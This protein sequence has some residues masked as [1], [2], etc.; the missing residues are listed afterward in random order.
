LDLL[1]SLRLPSASPRRDEWIQVPLTALI[2]DITASATALTLVLDD[3]HLISSPVVHQM[4]QFLLEHLPP[5]MHV[6]VGTREDPPL[7]LPLWRAR[8][9]VT[10]IR[11]RDLRFNAAETAAFLRQTMSL[12][13][14][15]EAVQALEARTEG[16]ITGLQLAALALQ[17]GQDEAQAFIAAVAGDNRYIIDYLIA[18]VLQRQPPA[19]RDFL[20]QT[21]IL[22]R[23]TA[24]LC[25]ALT[26]ETNSQATLDQLEEAN[27]FLVPLDHRR[28]WYRYHRLFAEFLRTRLTPEEQSALHQRAM[29]WHEE[30]GLLEQAIQHALALAELTGELQQAERLIR[31]AAED[32]IHSGG[33]L[34]LRGWLEALPDERVRASVEL[35]IYKG[36]VLALTGDMTLAQDYV[37]A[38]EA[39][40][41]QLDAPPAAWGKLVLLR[42]WI[43]LLGQRDHAAAAELA[44]EALEMLAEDQPHWRVIAL[45]MMAEALERT[46]NIA[47]AIML[48]RQAGQIGRAL[49]NQVFAAVVDMTLA[50]ALNNHGQRQQAVTVCQEAIERHSDATG[51][52]SP[53]AGLIFSRLGTLYYEANQLDLAC[54]CHER[55]LALSEKLAL[56]D[57][58]MFSHSF[59]VPTLYAQGRVTEALEA[60][61]KSQQLTT[62]TGFSDVDWYL[63]LQAN[64]YLKQGDLTFALHWAETAGLSPQDEPDYMRIEQQIIYA[65]VLLAQGRLAEAQSWLARLGNFAQER[66]LYRWRMTALVLQ[67][68]AAERQGDRPAA[69]EFLSQAL[70]LAAPEFYLRVFLDE[71]ELLFTLLPH[72]RH[73]APTFVDHL[74]AG[75]KSP[76]PKLAL[77]PQ[78]LVEPLS[79]RELEVLDLII[80]GLANREI[81]QKL[82]IAVGTVKRHINNIYGKLEVRSRTQAVARARALRL[83]E[84]D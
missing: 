37:A 24:G 4:L 59:A 28:E 61:E 70:Q 44:A 79:Q 26:G 56:R 69:L 7:P 83:L 80:A 67:A 76:A 33:M 54:Q 35:A 1:Q 40:L 47:Q 50:T 66:G 73:V 31:L 32:M 58:V 9:Q 3:Y 52:A 43:T 17:E 16:W 48:F 64:F 13:L 27:L 55:S 34:T 11:E 42:S 30:Q 75:A 12:P 77:A 38:A 57:Y 39:R 53:L 62:Q 46:R 84:Q 49:G 78:A 81:A 51:R 74:L 2:N 10:E 29:R 22:E 63:A 82:F 23:M 19:R 6:V 21:A 68:L 60:L 25:D 36:W 72:A 45:W 18:E 41:S 8:G 65:R 5:H 15:P 71:D 14:P 20:R